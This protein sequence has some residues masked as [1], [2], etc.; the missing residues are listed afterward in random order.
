MKRKIFAN[1][2]ADIVLISKIC[3]KLLQ[4]YSNKTTQLFFNE[5]RIDISPKKT[6]KCP[7]GK[8]QGAQHY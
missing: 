1:H 7:P 4:L 2:I 8:K 6:R 3:K 5:Q